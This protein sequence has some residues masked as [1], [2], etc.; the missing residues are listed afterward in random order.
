MPKQPPETNLL[1]AS[2]NVAQAGGDTCVDP[3]PLSKDPFILGTVISTPFYTGSVDCLNPSEGCWLDFINASTPTITVLFNVPACIN[4]VRIPSPSNV[5][6]FS[7]RLSDENATS[8][9][10]PGATGDQFT[11]LSSSS[12]DPLVQINQP[13]CGRTMV[14]QLLSTTDAGF[15]TKVTINASACF[16]NSSVNS[17]TVRPL[18][19]SSSM[20]SVVG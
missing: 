3:M 12:G 6:Q 14:L 2:L 11:L 17:T 13:P 18:A 9:P 5:K 15:P 4:R 16:R 8:I 7:F 1:V 20:F 10:L 19:A